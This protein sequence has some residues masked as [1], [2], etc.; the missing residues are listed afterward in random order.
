MSEE[1]L[2]PVDNL[3][4]PDPTSQEPVDKPTETV[5]P[6]VELK[7]EEAPKEE[8]PNDETESTGNE[9]IDGLLTE[10]KS[11]DIDVDKLFGNYEESGDEKDI[12]FAYLESKVGKLAAKGL[13]AGFRAENEKLERQAEAESKIIYDA[14]GGESMWDGIV[15]WIGGGESGLSR[16]GAEAYNTMLAAGGVQAE[17][18]A[19]ELSNMY[20]QSPGFTQDASLQQ[21][22]QTAQPTGIQPISRAEYVE[23]LDKVVRKSG[24][25]SPEAKALH[26]RRLFSMKNGA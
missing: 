2:E 9:Y 26:E 6:Q 11:N 5:T 20:R 19:R 8:A 24:E 1:V 22:D 17:L 21:A 3:V 10:F 25:H 7:P 12:D 15:K 18:A 13:I 23:Q 14:V 16:E 4:Q